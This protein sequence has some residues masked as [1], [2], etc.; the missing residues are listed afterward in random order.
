MERGRRWFISNGNSYG[1]GCVCYLGSVDS[2]LG[3]SD[4]WIYETLFSLFS[5]YLSLFLLPFLQAY[6][7]F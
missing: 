6:S 4:E 7:R 5:C 3:G 2:A 1:V